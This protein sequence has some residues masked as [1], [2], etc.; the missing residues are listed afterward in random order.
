[1]LLYHAKRQT[2][3]DDDKIAAQEHR[4][5]GKHGRR[6]P[7]RAGKP[8]ISRQAS[9]QHGKKPF[10]NAG[11]AQPAQGEREARRAA[12]RE[13]RQ[14]ADEPG[15]CARVSHVASEPF[16]E[17]FRRIAKTVCKA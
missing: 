5:S 17:R 16:E 7:A 4:D 12:E 9:L 1:M 14:R 2:P 11:K 10:V 15:F 8:V 3:A 13:A 6:L